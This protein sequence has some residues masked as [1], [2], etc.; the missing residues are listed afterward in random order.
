[1]SLISLF[2]DS[3]A[4]I[5]KGCIEPKTAVAVDTKDDL[6]KALQMLVE[7]QNRIET[8]Q[9]ACDKEM[10]ALQVTYMAQVIDDAALIAKLE[11]MIKSFALAN[12]SIFPVGKKTADFGVAKVSYK[13][14]PITLEVDDE[15]AAC[16]ELL[17]QG[18]WWCV[19]IKRTLVADAVKT[20]WGRIC[21]N[22]LDPQFIRLSNPAEGVTIKPAKVVRNERE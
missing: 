3:I 15:E 22:Y 9:A 17:D 14:M 21:D 6:Q 1:M 13:D 5:K 18:L 10:T 16:Q 4:A 19:R 8:V 2:K 20:H 11:P 7:A 12:K